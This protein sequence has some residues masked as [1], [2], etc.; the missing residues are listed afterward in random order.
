MMI[1]KTTYIVRSTEYIN[2]DDNN[3]NKA[4]NPR[5]RNTIV[6]SGKKKSQLQSAADTQS[7]R[8]MHLL[9]ILLWIQEECL[10]IHHVPRG[11]L[12]FVPTFMSMDIR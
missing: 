8:A 1:G 6:C 9:F 11:L 10:W 3:D 12:S 7:E 2:Y 4:F 5:M